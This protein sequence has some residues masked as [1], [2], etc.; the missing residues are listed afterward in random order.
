MKPSP[1]WR[2]ILRRGMTEY[3]KT[4][5]AFWYGTKVSK[6]WNCNAIRKCFKNCAIPAATCGLSLSILKRMS[7]NVKFW[8]LCLSFRGSSLSLQPFPLSVSSAVFSSCSVCIQA[9]F[10]RLN[11][12]ALQRSGH[13]QRFLYYSKGKP[14]VCVICV[15][16]EERLEK[17][18]QIPRCFLSQI[19]PKS[20]NIQEYSS[21]T[22]FLVTPLLLAPLLC[23]VTPLS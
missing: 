23:L 2:N 18:K 14:N 3:L 20:L 22:R 9:F 15:K 8:N 11:Q 12:N 21:V 10:K 5:N 16:G 6:K 17:L 7:W 19:A 4:Q 1:E 13:S